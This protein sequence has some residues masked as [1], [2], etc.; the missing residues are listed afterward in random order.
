MDEGESDVFSW[1][2]AIAS[3]RGIEVLVLMEDESDG[4]IVM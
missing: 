3:D 1:R 4:L 2:R